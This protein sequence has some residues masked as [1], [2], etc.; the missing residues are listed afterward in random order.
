MCHTNEVLVLRDAPSEPMRIDQD[1]YSHIRHHPGRIERERNQCNA[2][3][4][5]KLIILSRTSS[6]LSGRLSF[7]SSIQI[8][9]PPSYPGGTRYFHWFYPVP[10]H[11]PHEEQRFTEATW[12]LMQRHYLC[13]SIVMLSLRVCH[14]YT[15]LC[16]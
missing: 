5:G 15:K 3:K 11:F 14:I 7:R 13:I 2:F 16:S 10:H 4:D 12:Y 6:N 8:Q 1:P 9:I